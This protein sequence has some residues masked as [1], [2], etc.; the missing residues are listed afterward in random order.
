MY[1]QDDS[2]KYNKRN[3]SSETRRYA[4]IRLAA[5]TS[6]L[7]QVDDSDGDD[8]HDDN[9]DGDDDD[10]NNMHQLILAYRDRG[11]SNILDICRS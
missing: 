1:V 10:D 6:S 5:S 9:Y 4:A 3:V 2:K 11:C 8:D 7:S